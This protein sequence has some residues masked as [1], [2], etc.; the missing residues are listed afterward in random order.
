M[1]RK[2]EIA[3]IAREIRMIKGQLKKSYNDPCNSM[4][5]D[6]YYVAL[7]GLEECHD[8]FIREN[9]VEDAFDFLQQLYDISDDFDFADAMEDASSKY[10]L[11]SAE[12]ELLK[13]K[14]DNEM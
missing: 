9:K 10:R 12:Y 8:E 7:E 3:K 4:S 11:N 13:W 1:S 14:Y 2:Q 6:D 5:Y